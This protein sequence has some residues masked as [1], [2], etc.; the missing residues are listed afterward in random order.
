LDAATVLQPE[1]DAI[2]QSR[3]ATAQ[4]TP[5]TAHLCGFSRQDSTYPESFGLT[6]LTALDLEHWVVCWIWQGFEL[7]SDLSA[8]ALQVCLNYRG[9]PLVGDF[10][11]RK[12]LSAPPTV[13]ELPPT[14]CA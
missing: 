9:F 14:G 11:C 12:G 5:K 4:E 7:A 2:G 8:P 3:K 1:P 10:G 13:L 6:L